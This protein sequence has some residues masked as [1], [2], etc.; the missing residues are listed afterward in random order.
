MSTLL[1]NVCC[2]LLSA[3][4]ILSA[5]GYGLAA[6]AA[7]N[8]ATPRAKPAATAGS[9]LDSGFS[10]KKI[11]SALSPRPFPQVPPD[12]SNRWADNSDAALL[13]QRL[14]FDTRFSGPLLAAEHDGSVF[15]SGLGVQGTPGKVA[16][17]S[18]HIP[19]AV[20]SDTRSTKQQVSLGAAWTH[21]RSPSLI[22]AGYS[23]VL[24]WDGRRDAGFNQ[25]FGAIE[26]SAEMNSSRLFVAQQMGRLYKAEYE[27]IFKEAFPDLSDFPII[28]SEDAGCKT[29]QATPTTSCA[30]PHDDR[31]N[32]VVANFGKAMNAYL[33]KLT[34]GAGRFDAWVNG[35][36]NAITAQEQRGA[37][38]FVGKG[39]CVTCH[40]G[41]QFTDQKFHNI[42]LGVGMVS[43]VIRVGGDPGAAQG[44]PAMLAD[45]LNVR[46]KFSDGYDGRLDALARANPNDLLGAFRTPSLRCVEK[47]PS[48]THS[49]QMRTLTDVVAFFNQGGAPSGTIGKK[50]I[51]PLNLTLDEE[52]DLV[53]FMRT[54]TGPGPAA[55]LLTPPANP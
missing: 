19:S 14:F 25:V 53:A 24:M 1:R 7:K 39:R 20:F 4:A 10:N 55:E 44:V 45:P 26:A 36:A 30:K 13:G 3:A 33:R 46:G 34:C 48:F 31:V 37:A 11:F 18:C 47:R 32:R 9:V 8:D 28:A 15:G 42:G 27:R 29:E 23:S 49:A 41:P 2:G 16:C 35:D 51:V 54:L 43:L 5:S 40:S 38:L 17:S 21:R 12:V 22:D 52:A 50:E 6:P